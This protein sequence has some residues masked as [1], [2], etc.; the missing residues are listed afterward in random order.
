M[1]KVGFEDLPCLPRGGFENMSSYEICQK[2]KKINNN[3]IKTS[4]IVCKNQEAPDVGRKTIARMNNY[5]LITR[6]PKLGGGQFHPVAS[7]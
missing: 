5:K 1:Q 4:T 2:R 6:T 3:E 7:A